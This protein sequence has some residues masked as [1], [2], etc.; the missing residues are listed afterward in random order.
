LTFDL[1]QPPL[2]LFSIVSAPYAAGIADAPCL[3]PPHIAGTQAQVPFDQIVSLLRLQ[4]PDIRRVGTMVNAAEPNSINGVEQIT[5]HAEALGLTVESAPIASLADVPIAAETLLDKGVEAILISSSAL[6]V[7]GLSAITEVAAEYGVPVYSP[8]VGNVHRGAHV[9]AGFDDFYREG[10]VVGRML[11]A[12][13]ERTFDV[14]SL[15]INALPSLGVALNLDAAAEASF[16]FSEEMLA[17]ADYVIE[18]GESTQDR[19]PPN[20]QDMILEERRAA[21]LDFLAGLECTDEMIAEQQA[22]LDAAAE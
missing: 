13:L 9:G 16:S 3:K 7:R 2:V 6:E 1:E 18:N 20:L 19:T 17:L 10:V 11:A 22:Q 14:S 4:Q 15:A 12:H 5:Q 21:D 8:A